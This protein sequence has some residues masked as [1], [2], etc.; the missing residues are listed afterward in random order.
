M[1][2]IISALLIFSLCL[3]LCACQA[4]TSKI[5]W[6]ETTSGP[7]TYAEP[8]GWIKQDNYNITMYVNSETSSIISVLVFDK[9]GPESLK[10]KKDEF[11]EGFTEGVSGFDNKKIKNTK[12]SGNYA[13]QLEY[14]Q[15]VGNKEMRN[16]IIFTEH[17]DQIIGYQVTIPKD[18]YDKEISTYKPLFKALKITAED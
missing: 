3:S 18:H 10:D 17:E 11:L 4:Q 5:E 9:P 15:T 7:V 8:K 6:K 12:V 1:K 13:F 16:R 14:D 2:K